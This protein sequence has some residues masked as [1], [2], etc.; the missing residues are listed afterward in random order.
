MPEQPPLQKYPRTSHLEGS[1]FQAGDEDLA[2]VPFAELAGRYLVVEEKVDGANAALSF[3]P[4]GDLLL[5]SRGHY[6]TGGPRERHFTLFKRWAHHHAPAF[7]QVLGERYILYGEWLYARHTIF[8]DRL[9]HYFLEFDVL[10]RVSGQFLSTSRRRSLVRGLPIVSVPVLREG[11]LNAPE[12][13]V[14][15]IGPSRFISPDHL[16]TLRQICVSTGLDAHRALAETDPS[17]QMEGLYVKVEEDGAVQDRFKFVRPSFLSAVLQSGTHWLDRP[18]I[19][20]QLAPGTQ[21]F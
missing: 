14:E 12:T 5:Q 16:E 11:R 10:D 8:Y 1:R 2:S 17:G 3:S 19:P 15:G 20:N 6:L 18:I 9:P 13:L 4:S 21:L 7:S